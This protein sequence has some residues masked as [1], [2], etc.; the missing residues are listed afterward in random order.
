MLAPTIRAF[1]VSPITT[2]PTTLFADGTGGWGIGNSREMVPEEFATGG[3]SGG[4]AFEAYELQDEGKFMRNVQQDSQ[5][6][7]NDEWFEIM[8]VAAFAGIA[9]EPKMGKFDL[10]DD[11]NDDLDVSIPDDDPF[12]NF[13]SN[14]RDSSITRMDEDTGAPGVW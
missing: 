4:S 8:S 10:D 3:A 7:Q 14:V 9:I 2:T 5:Q 13:N 11:D 6:L 1:W 12:S